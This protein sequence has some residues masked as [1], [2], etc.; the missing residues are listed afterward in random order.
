MTRKAP[1]EHGLQNLEYSLELESGP[2]L[3]S[4]IALGL[5]RP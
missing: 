5:G 4:I 3:G 1:L 2:E